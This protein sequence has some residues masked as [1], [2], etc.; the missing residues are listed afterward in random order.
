MKPTVDPVEARK[1][2][3]DELIR[4][5]AVETGL[6]VDMVELLAALALPLVKGPPR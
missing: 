3:G 1:L 5:F 6:P 4:A 2:I